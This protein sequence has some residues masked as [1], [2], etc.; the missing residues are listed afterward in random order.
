MNLS[1]QNNGRNRLWYLAQPFS[2]YEG[3]IK[4]AFEV[5]SREAARLIKLRIPVFAPIPHSYPIAL[6][7]DISQLDHSVWLPADQPLIDAC[8]GIIVLRMK[9]WDES[10][11]V[12]YE[13]D[14]FAKAGKPRIDMEVGTV[15]AEF[16]PGGRFA[17]DA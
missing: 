1:A 6:Y 11:G 4:E 13:I 15:P 3:G 2:K 8:T 12:A 10:F 16:L 9:G 7:G 17:P 14:Q 5:G